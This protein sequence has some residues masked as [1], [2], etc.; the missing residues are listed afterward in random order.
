MIYTSF[1]D[2]KESELTFL[3][4]TI[5]GADDVLQSL[6]ESVNRNLKYLEAQVSCYNQGVSAFSNPVKITIRTT[7]CILA[8]SV[9]ILRLINVHSCDLL[10]NEPQNP[11]PDYR[12]KDIDSRYLKCCETLRKILDE[13][14]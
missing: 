6:L 2:F 4:S 7:I 3:L 11:V 13:D 1:R 5:I 8:K 10:S 12:L 14:K 9:G